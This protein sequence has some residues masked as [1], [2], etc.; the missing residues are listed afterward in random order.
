VTAAVGTTVL[1]TAPNPGLSANDKGCLPNWGAATQKSQTTTQQMVL[2]V[3]AAG[4][5][6]TLQAD[7]V[8]LYT[9]FC[10][11]SGTCCHTNLCNTSNIGKIN[12]ILLILS[13]LTKIFF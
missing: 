13:V 12:L 9:I 5:G 1:V 6:L 8:S 4:T 10:V 7:L 2:Q 3:T 11:T